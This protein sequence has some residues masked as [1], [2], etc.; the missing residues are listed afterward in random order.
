MTAALN[1]RDYACAKVRRR[2]DSYLSGEL[3]VDLS[4]EILEHLDR[5][6]ECRAELGAREKLRTATRLALV[7]APD[8]RE[9]FDGEVRALLERTPRARRWPAGF[10]LA[11][12]LLVAASVAGW[13]V[14]GRA[15]RGPVPG[16]APGAVLQSAVADFA[17]RNHELCT[18]THVW[19]LDAP[20]P[21]ALEAGLDPRLVAALRAARAHLSGYEPVSAHTCSPAGETVF[22]IV[23]R[24]AGTRGPDGLVSVLATGADSRFAARVARAEIASAAGPAG[25]SMAAT[26]APDGRL[27]LLV[28]DGNRAEAAALGR[29]VLP[30]LATA[31]SR[32]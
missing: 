21:E 31:F 27:L 30:A 15:G 2:L 22:H 28:A 17:A 10:L 20:A 16:G 19:P 23:F 9:G 8:P 7:P 13:L 3:S 1:V 32:P 26:R 5:C 18:L 24:R 25:L 29:A 14:V 12:S 4:H 11:A 6:P